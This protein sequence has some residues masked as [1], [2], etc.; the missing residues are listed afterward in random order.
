MPLVPAC[1]F[2]GGLARSPEM[3]RLLGRGL[4]L[5]LVTPPDALFAGAVGAALIAADG[6]P[7]S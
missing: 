1:V 2:T 4:G 6:L 5:T 7:S 3:A